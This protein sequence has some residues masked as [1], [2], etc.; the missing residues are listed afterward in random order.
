MNYEL[1]PTLQRLE[2]AKVDAAPRIIRH[3]V[4]PIQPFFFFSYQEKIKGKR[5]IYFRPKAGGRIKI[6]YLYVSH[7][8]ILLFIYFSKNLIIKIYSYTIHSFLIIFLKKYII[9]I[10]TN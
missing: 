9:F 10:L 6:F 7:P 8:L 1:G 4:V 2:D 5:R 3:V